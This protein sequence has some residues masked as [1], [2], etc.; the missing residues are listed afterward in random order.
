MLLFS[1]F[2]LIVTLVYFAVIGWIL[3]FVG[4]QAFEWLKDYLPSWLL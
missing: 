3:Y 4:M 2:W 1:F